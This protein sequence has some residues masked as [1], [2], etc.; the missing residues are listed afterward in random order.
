MDALRNIGIVAHIDAGKTTLTEQLLVLTGFLRAP[1]SVEDGT[2]VADWRRPERER[3]I[4][5]GSAAMT[6]RWRGHDITI[7]DTPGHVDFTLEV[8]RTLTVIEGVVLVLSAPDGVQAQTQT[9]WHQAAHH[10]L[11][12]VGFVNK[13]DR[14]GV[15]DAA[16]QAQI[17]DVL[18]LEPVPLQ[19]PLSWSDDRLV[20]LDLVTEQVLEWEE[21]SRR[22]GPRA[23]VARAVA[24][25]EER[26]ELLLGR[27]R[28]ADAVSPWD[29]AFTE[30]ILDDRVPPEADWR[31]AIAAAVRAR[32]CLPLVYG[33]AR[34]GIGPA[35]LLDAVVDYLPCPAKGPRRKIF[36]VSDP[37]RSATWPPEEPQ[38]TTAFVFKTERRGPDRRVAWV[39]VFAGELR[40]GAELLRHRSA[41]P[42]RVGELVRLMGGTDEPLDSLGEGAIGA[43]LGD[44]GPP[45]PAMGDTLVEGPL[46]WAFE[47][48]A[49]PAPVIA[50]ALEAPDAEGDLAM[51]RALE[52]LVSDDPSLAV[53]SD[54]ITG[55]IQLLG[56]GELH[57]ELATESL[58]RDRQL[59]CRIGAPR[60]WLRQAIATTGVGRGE[61]VLDTVPG[62]AVAVAVRVAPSDAH[63]PARILPIREAIADPAGAEALRAALEH[64]LQGGAD[65]VQAELEVIEIAERGAGLTP[66]AY[67]DAATEAVSAA[68]ANAGPQPA[69]PWVALEVTVPEEAVGRV[70]GD[71]ARR[72]ARIH[73]STS[74]G[75]LQTLSA[76]A[77]LAE[78][79]RYATDLRSMTSGRGSFSMRPTGHRPR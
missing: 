30:Q 14:P 25:D 13:L 68:I 79:L 1:G 52:D 67:W 32:G 21:L 12:A 34:A 2:T 17:R 16:L 48:I 66:R 22:S 58:V 20:L 61:V 65:L 24:T 36:D 28:L 44:A 55:Q 11:P 3:G 78:M 63:G 72:R 35:A 45:F 54:P 31:R 9:V 51:R 57:L 70:S 10:G 43:I 50:V 75:T 59:P 47:P 19:I 74:R 37:E 76:S 60:A 18:G 49:V 39:R 5:I 26:Y 73:A 71:L 15:D 56:M 38:P 53:L 77:P 42:V 62:G 41:V 4:T 46:R 7:V 64:V 29:D 33:V 8:E 27:E 69:E 40:P 23:P 6:S